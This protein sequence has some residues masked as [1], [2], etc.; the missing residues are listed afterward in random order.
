MLEFGEDQKKVVDYTEGMVVVRAC[1]GSGKT[2]SVTARIAELL[3][4]NQ[5][6]KKGI[7]A[8]S[9]TNVACEEIQDKLRGEFQI[10]RLKHPNYLGTL[11]SFINQFIFLPY[12][13][14]VMGCDRRPTLVGQPHS[15]W[16]IKRWDT[17]EY[18]YFDKTTFNLNGELIPLV[19]KVAFKYIP[20]SKYYTKSGKVHGSIQKLINVKHEFHKKGYATQA[21]ANYFSLK[22]LMSYPLI[23]DNIANKFSHFIIDEAQDTD[24]VLMGI[25]D[26][27]TQ[28]GAHNFML[29]GDRDQSIF[30]WNQARPELFDN[31]YDAWNKIDIIQNRRSSQK[32][33]DFTN[34]FSSFT[35]TEAVSEEVKNCAY[36]PSFIGYKKKKTAK[37]VWV[38]TPK[39]SIASFEPILKDFLQE[40][41]DYGIEVNQKNVAVLYR[42]KSKIELLG[43]TP[44]DYNF[45]VLPWKEKNFFVRS[46]AEGKFLYDNGKHKLG[47]KRMEKGI[48]ELLKRVGDKDHFFLC[49]DSFVDSVIESEGIKAY[50]KKM[51]SIIDLLVPTKGV[52]IKEWAEKSNAN[53]AKEKSPIKLL[54]NDVGSNVSMESYLGYLIDKDSVLPFYHGTVH[55]AKGKTF[56]AALLVL[57]KGSPKHYKTMFNK[58]L[59]RSTKDEEE[60]RIVYVGMTRPRKILKVAVPDDDVDIWNHYMSN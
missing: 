59:E 13:H 48:L 28:K 47:F 10:G 5:N 55:S 34:P 41:A 49:E 16:T 56:E 29:V 4:H 35:S 25:V 2:F 39:E 26:V 51:F 3:K 46:I 20:W 45:E 40:C 18:Q 33:C 32:I 23:A 60:L 11:D 54:V 50:R 1:P 15:N 9:Y 44:P 17:D 38:V 42:G 53:L 58:P 37:K 27:L 30:E 36:Q 21:D 12:G 19:P 7:A 31:K 57:D 6:S 52:T 14:L 43:L 24:E 8:L 22:I